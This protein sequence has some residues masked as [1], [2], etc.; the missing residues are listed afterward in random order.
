MW[1]DAFIT[2]FCKTVIR[3]LGDGGIYVYSYSCYAGPAVLP[4]EYP[5]RE[6]SP[7]GKESSQD[8]RQMRGS[9]SNCQSGK[10]S[11]SQARIIK[12]IRTVLK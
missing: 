11:K 6:K 5:L 9:A 4:N 10:H 8:H 7:C 2:P 12:T 3:S 1:P